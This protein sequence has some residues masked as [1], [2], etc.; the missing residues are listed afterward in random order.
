MELN[1]PTTGKGDW[2]RPTDRERY[3]KNYDD[4]DWGRG[5]PKMKVGVDP[6]ET[7]CFGVSRATRLCRRCSGSG[8]VWHVSRNQ[9]ASVESV[10]CPDC[11]LG[12]V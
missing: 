4:I 5:K 10:R 1:K 9:D 8:W 12:R 2:E 7:G 3:R 11:F 6:A